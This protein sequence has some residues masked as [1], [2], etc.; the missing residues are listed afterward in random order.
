VTLS[1]ADGKAALERRV[2]SSSESVDACVRKFS[3]RPREWRVVGSV[4]GS[5]EVVMVLEHK[6]SLKSLLVLFRS[7]PRAQRQEASVA[8]SFTD[9]LTNP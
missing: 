2:A 3:R 6:K 9:Y 5:K 8:S 1:L 7:R 4:I